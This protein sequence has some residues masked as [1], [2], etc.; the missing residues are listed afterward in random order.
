[1][2]N[3][4]IPKQSSRLNLCD[5]GS[6]PLSQHAD[7]ITETQ[8]WLCSLDHRDTDLVVSTGSQ[9][10]RPGCVHRITDTQTWLCSLDHRDTDLVVFTGSQRHR[11]GCVH[12]ITETQTWLC[13]RD[14]IAETQTWLCSRDWI[15]ETQTWLCSQDHRDTDL[16]VFQRSFH[17]C[18]KNDDASAPDTGRTV[19]N[20]W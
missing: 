16:V 11:P 1:M 10:H 18:H 4:L 17:D 2:R 13:S 8:T 15:T 7:W 6:T 3:D 12:W 20:D 19:N 9:R 5:I 14:W